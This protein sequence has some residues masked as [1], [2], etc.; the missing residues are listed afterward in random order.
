MKEARNTP[1]AN[2]SKPM[3]RGMRQAQRP[4][5][6]ECGSVYNNRTAN[7]KPHPTRNTPNPINVQARVSWPN[8]GVYDPVTHRKAQNGSENKGKRLENW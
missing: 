4:N 8:V 7:E 5:V 2:P 1:R 3:E 6:G